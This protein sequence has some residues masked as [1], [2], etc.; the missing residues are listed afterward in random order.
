VSI[1]AFLIIDGLLR[2][3]RGWVHRALEAW[4][5]QMIGLM[6][7][8][9]YAWHLLLLD[10]MGS[11]KDVSHVALFIISLTVVSWLSYAH[12]EFRRVRDVRLL[13]PAKKSD[14]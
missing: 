13:F 6:C 10:R 2:A 8:S 1:S 4:W 9:I 12:I 11:M 5:L 7:Y 14:S 3:P